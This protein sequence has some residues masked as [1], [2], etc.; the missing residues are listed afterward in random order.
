M[1]TIIKLRMLGVPDHILR[2]FNN[3]PTADLINEEIVGYVMQ[4]TVQS[5][6]GAFQFCDI[7]DNLVDGKSSKT[8]IEALR[9][10]N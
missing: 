3:L 8:R 4:S 2:Y 1:K 10:G 5:D 9:N 6:F 7:M